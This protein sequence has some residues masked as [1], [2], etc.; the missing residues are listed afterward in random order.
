MAFLG[1]V[2]KFIR[3]FNY[4]CMSY[5]VILNI[6]YI[7]QLIISYFRLR[8]ER[9]EELA[10]D[11][12]HY[13]NSD[14]LLPITLIVPA[15]NEEDNIVHNVKS[16]MKLNYP[17]YEV[18]VVNDGSKDKTH[19]KMIEAFELKKVNPSIKVSIPTQEIQ[20]VYYN[21]KYPNLVYVDKLNGGKSDALN[22]G[23]NIS[24]YPLFACL[25][26]DSRI[27]KNSLL[28][29]GEMFIKDSTTVVAGGFVRIANGSVIE[30][31]EWRGFD[32]PEKS[33]EKFQIVEYFRSFLYG[34]VAWGKSLLIVSGA[35][36]LFKKDAVIEVGGYKNNTIGEDMEIVVRMHHK[37]K[38]EKRKYSVKFCDKAICWTQCPM[39]IK[40]L[41]GQRRRW[42]VGLF[43]TL[44]S[45]FSMTF[46]PRYGAVGFLSMPYNFIFELLG[47]IVESLGYLIIPFSV[48]MGELNM[49]FFV[50]YLLLSVILGTM[51]SVGGILLEQYTRKGCFTPDQIMKLSIYAFLENLGYR[52]LIVLFR[53]E[54]V[55]RFR[56]Y[57]TSWGKIKRTQFNKE[58]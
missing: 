39:S 43:D 49:F 15:Y 34:R 2:R 13:A 29:L 5:T 54:G 37:F 25:D 55:L 12:E 40:D 56:K 57:R 38:K 31:G 8:K 1:I 45:H 22:A 19:F 50:M 36:G 41:R 35:F 20:G 14:N 32:L 48:I 51:L 11:Y 26:A 10:N 28:M 21:S 17:N 58:K 16:L 46:N 18:V 30:D 52:Q 3:I 53:L 47:V 42:Q 7:I 9:K 44:L 6:A 24:K 4:F 27:E 33:I 23:I